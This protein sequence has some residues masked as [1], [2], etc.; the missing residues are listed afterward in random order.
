MSNQ[1]PFKIFATINLEMSNF[2]YFNYINCIKEGKIPI[3]AHSHNLTF[4]VLN[5]EAIPHD[6]TANK[7]SLTPTHQKLP[8]L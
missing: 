6:Y 8:Y 5:T 1:L 2:E 4:V 7:T 3:F